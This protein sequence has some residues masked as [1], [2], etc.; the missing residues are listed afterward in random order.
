MADVSSK[1][2]AYFL[3]L[4]EADSEELLRIRTL[5]ISI[6]PE[7]EEAMV[8]GVPGFKY[9]KKSL[10]C[11]AAFKNHCGFYPLSPN[12][13]KTF[14]KEL[15]AFETAKGTIRFTKANPIPDSLI[16]EMVNA[17]V[18]EIDSA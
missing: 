11:Y 14:S 5:I 1:I 18:S 10:V 6:N 8:Y 4:S 16:V 15:E 3:K 7:F 2:E 13:I 9:K 17:R 12:V